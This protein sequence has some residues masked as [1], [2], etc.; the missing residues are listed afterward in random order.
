MTTRR[1]SMPV[2]AKS[3]YGFTTDKIKEFEEAFNVFDKDGNGMI[4][5]EE[6]GEVLRS[7]GERPTYFELKDA[8]EAM[9]GD[10]EYFSYLSYIYLIKSFTFTMYWCKQFEEAFNVFDKDGNG[11]ITTEELGE[12]L[13]SL[14][15]RPTYFELKDAMEAMDG[16]RSGT[17]EF[18]EFLSMMSKNKS[19]DPEKELLDVFH[20]FDQN[21]DG[22][23]DADEL[24]DVLTKIGEVITKAEVREMIQEA[25]V[26][27]DGT[28]NFTEFKRILTAK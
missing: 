22:H 18:D 11:M 7:L 15:E 12:V 10:R 24:Y 21:G 16:D 3:D 9:D 26:D 5:T 20:V 4:T 28:V 19:R 1:Q 14:G 8:M 27:G 25:D 23:I 6:L 17:I 2:V 13:R